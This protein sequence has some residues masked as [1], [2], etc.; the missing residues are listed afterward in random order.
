MSDNKLPLKVK[1]GIRDSWEKEDAPV[2]KAIA[3]VRDTVGVNIRVD[4]EWQILIAELDVAYPDKGTF[5]PSIAATVDAFCCALVTLA[6]DEAN[7]EWADKFLTKISG[8]VRIFFQVVK[9]RDL[10]L[11]WLEA[12]KSFLIGLPKHPVPTPSHM[13]SLF[14]GALLSCFDE[15]TKISAISE[16]PS[17]AVDDWSDVSVDTRTGNAAVIDLPNRQA[18]SQAIPEF[19]IMPD[20]D[21][22]PRP[23]DLTMEPPYYLA[24]HDGGKSLVEVQCSH[25]PTLEFLSKYLQRFC[26]INHNDSRKPP[27]VELKLHQSAF[28]LGLVYDRLTI[29]SLAVQQVSPM[30]VLP[31]VESVLG[32]KTVTV[33]RGSWIF[34]RDVE[35]RGGRY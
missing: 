15:N 5:V 4:P 11:T 6:D 10:D 7:A 18:A 29:T 24:V 30:L 27:V 31:L 17:S 32:Y 35:F 34:R 8:P 14:R 20:I 28:G 12:R 21:T 13:Q 23:D 19:D 16:T 25:S 22:L 3:N 1:V 2:N 33:E 26:R 9:S